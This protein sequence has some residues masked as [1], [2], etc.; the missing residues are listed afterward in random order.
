MT[1]L[2][3]A[4]LQA[5]PMLIVAVLLVGLCVG[6]FL[7]VVI[8]RLPRMLQA[9]W[10]RDARDILSQ[11]AAEQPPF[12]LLR[13]PSN[14][15]QCGHRIRWY[16]NIPVASW[17]WLR[18]KCSACGTPIGL[19]YPA[20]EIINAL[21]WAGIAWQHGLNGT[22]LGYML[23][24]S[25]LLALFWID[26]DTQLLPDDLT[27]PLVW[28]GL[29]FQLVTARVALTSAVIGAMAGYLVLWLVYHGFRLLTGKEGM[30]YGDFKLFAAL[31]AWFGWPALVPMLLASSL[32]GALIG[33]ALMATGRLQR[34]QAFAFGP[35]IALVGLVAIFVEPQRWLG[36]VL[37]G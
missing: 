14:C 18:G 27:L 23:L 7:N 20:V 13:P 1:A 24:A 29:L 17:L 33:G 15:R 28:G 36:A 34:G 35:F 6:S 5:Q 16:E 4:E 32:G 3:A 31:G 30:G 11:P 37:G 8:Y 2:S 21:L 9:G 26:W 22:A 12:D 19:R 25:T 10:E